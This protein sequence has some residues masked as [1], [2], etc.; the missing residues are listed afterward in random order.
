VACD[1][2]GGADDCDDIV[3]WG[4]AHLAFLRGFAEFHFGIPSADWL[5]CIMNHIHPK[6]FVECFL[7]LVAACWP[8]NSTSW[9]STA[10]PRGG[11]EAAYA[12]M[13]VRLC[14]GEPP[15]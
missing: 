10:R 13:R 15:V 7:L 9:Q 3:D 12:Q 14:R 5:R 8:D 2:I 6:L 1:T 11:I 4:K